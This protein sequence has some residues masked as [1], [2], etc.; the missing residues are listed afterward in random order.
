[1]LQK[2]GREFERYGFQTN[3]QKLDYPELPDFEHW[4]NSNPQGVGTTHWIW[5]NQQKFQRLA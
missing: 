5:I 1:M 2:L 3:V 4:I